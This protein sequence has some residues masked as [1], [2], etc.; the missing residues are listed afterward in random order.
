MLTVSTYLQYVVEPGDV[1]DDDDDVE[2]GGVTQDYKC[3]L[4]LT[5]LQDPVTSYAPT[6]TFFGLS[7]TN[8]TFE[9]FR[10]ACNHSFSRAAIREYLSR[11]P[12]NCP[13]TGCNKRITLADLKDDKA[14][15]RRVKEHAR[16]EAMR[17]ED[18][19]VD[20]EIID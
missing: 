10:K 5:P 4:T 17:A 13:A 1:S 16:R 3:P 9:N 20:A 7:G 15:E 14:L 19:D 6:F 12:K 18:E 2:V 8:N 11:G